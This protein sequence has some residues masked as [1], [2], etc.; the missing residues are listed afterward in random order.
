MF[1]IEEITELADSSKS[2]VIFDLTTGSIDHDKSQI[3]IN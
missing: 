2:E 1:Q 3:I